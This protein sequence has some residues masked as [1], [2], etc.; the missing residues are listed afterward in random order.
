MSVR[1]G[2]SITTVFTTRRFDTG[3]ATNAD[4]TPTGTLYVNGTADAASVTVTNITTGRYKA[5]VTL[6]TLAAGDLV[7][8]NIN[9]TVNS[10]TDNAVVWGDTKD[11]ILSA[12]F[13]PDV[14]VTTI[15]AVSTVAVTTI[16]AVIGTSINPPTFDIAV[17]S[18]TA[19]TIILASTDAY[20]NAVPDVDQYTYWVFQVVGG[21]GTGQ[22]VQTTTATTG[23]RA[24][25]VLAGTMT[26]QL[27]VTSQLLSLGSYATN[28]TQINGH[29]TSG[30]DTDALDGLAVMGQNYFNFSYL[31]TNVSYVLGTALTEG[32]SGRL[33]GGF[34]K[35]FNVGSP[36]GTVNSL[37][38]VAPGNAGAVLIAGTNT[39]DTKL[40]GSTG[41]G[42][43]IQGASGF[44]P[45]QVTAVGNATAIG[46]LASGA[47]GRCIVFNT[48]SGVCIEVNGAITAADN[49][50]VIDLGSGERAA[51]IAALVA[52]IIN[53]SYTFGDLEKDLAAAVGGTV[54][55]D[56]ATYEV[57]SVGWGV[58]DSNMAVSGVD[59]NRTIIRS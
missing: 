2:Q 44:I 13:V 17:A 8:L 34:V 14:N 46:V 57:P 10:V 5:A 11:L 32:A 35:W 18:A 33:A 53:G 42:L 26:T 19:G 47:G 12:G 49:A 48:S 50:N 25:N 56:G 36:T 39:G 58:A 22:I 41:N 15:N 7:E 55:D 38:D 16:N 31:T 4:T 37:P 1:S 29:S 9:A 52:S 3:A 21:T 54:T 24:Y 45:L 27:D 6:P 59:G 30:F 51:I 40:V 23:A 28:T 20:G 43:L